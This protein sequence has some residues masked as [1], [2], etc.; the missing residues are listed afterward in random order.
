MKAILK[1]ISLSIL[2]ITISFANIINVPAD[3][4]SI[5]GGIDMAVDGD[6]VLVQPGTY[7][8]NINFDGKKI[9]VGSL[10]LTTYEK[11]YISKTIINGNRRG[12][13]FTFNGGEDSTTVLSGFTITNGAGGAG[14]GG[15]CSC[16]YYGGGI[17]CYESS[18]KLTNLLI[19]GNSGWAGG[20]MYLQDSNPKL[21]NVTITD[22]NAYMGGGIHFGY[23][24][25]G[26]GASNSNPNFDSVNRCSIYS[27]FA[28]YGTDLYLP[29]D[30]LILYVNVDTFTV[31]HPTSFHTYPEKN[32]NFDILTSK[33]EQ[34]NSDLYV[35]PSG[36]NNNNGLTEDN[37][38]KSI[39][40]AF[41]K[42]LA[43][44]LNPHTIYLANGE[45]D[46][47]LI[48]NCPIS[49]PEYVSICG[50]S[51]TG[52][53]FDS[54]NYGGE[55]FTF[56]SAKEVT[57]ENMTII[58]EGSSRG[59][60]FS[61]SNS[62]IK[63]VILKDAMIWLGS[64]SAHIEK[65]KIT[66]NTGEAAILMYGSYATL[67]NV[68]FTNNMGWLAGGLRIEENSHVNLINS[69]L[70]DNKSEF[71][72]IGG[73]HINSESS[74]RIIN[75]IIWD[76]GPYEIGV[77]SGGD[78]PGTSI[79]IT[80]SLIKDG[81]TGIHV[82]GGQN[83]LDWL[84][85]NIMD[86]P[87]FNDPSNG[88][89]TLRHNSPCIDKGIQDTMIVYN[90]GQDTLIVP[91]MEYIGSAPDMGAYEFGDPVKVKEQIEI[92][93]RYT[94]SQNY[95][96]PFNP[97]TT[98]EFTLPK[99]DFVELK[100][101]NILGKEVSTLVSTKLNQGNHTYTFDG[102]TLASGIYYY[103]LVAGDYREVK[104]MILLK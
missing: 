79:L 17:S 81:A 63:N 42:I 28:P 84:Q 93:K 21:S 78:L 62:V 35:S 71:R 43:D 38:L 76:N 12:S 101:Y 64:S 11:S 3:I 5:Q 49:L 22:N 57:I 90:N 103:Q 91:L 16:F 87:Q 60:F 59:L 6:T 39:S 52:V 1:S 61:G 53:I 45:Y 46:D 25:G 97:S 50:E 8:E 26:C 96:N 9:T 54:K 83:E 68:E 32:F 88:D 65:V 36:N 58:G 14:C 24:A 33:L 27:N 89:Y 4:D 75:S 19:T 73:I 51:N 13:V 86:N 100:V 92:P 70:S 20:G 44:S 77:N 99:S 66:G 2:F 37:P 67:M 85:E 104:K 102:N 23:S 48:N 82:L 34:S 72:D 98:I 15:F 31:L 94:L 55:V 47:E 80:N 95:P 30:S 69:T 56:S 74:L 18:P 29:N 10:F 7:L 40:Y 41:M